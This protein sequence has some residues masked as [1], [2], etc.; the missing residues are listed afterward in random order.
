MAT[1]RLASVLEEIKSII[2]SASVKSI[3]PFKKA[4][5]VNSPASANLAPFLNINSNTLLVGAIPP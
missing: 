4:R 5:L 2:D 3:R 1:F